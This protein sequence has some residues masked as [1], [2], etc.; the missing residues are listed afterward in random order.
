MN[1]VKT[2][3]FPNLVQAQPNNA[4]IKM[5]AME[6]KDRNNWKTIGMSNDFRSLGIIFPARHSREHQVKPNLYFFKYIVRFTE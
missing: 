3:G 6:K 1:N 5:G 4:T 2:A